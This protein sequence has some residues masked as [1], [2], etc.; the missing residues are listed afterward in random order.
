MLC[1]HVYGGILYGDVTA[2]RREAERENGYQPFVA[3]ISSSRAGLVSHV[4]TNPASRRHH[5]ELVAV[6]VELILMG[7]TV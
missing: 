4:I 1:G 3:N 7:Q 5:S 2:A 6:G